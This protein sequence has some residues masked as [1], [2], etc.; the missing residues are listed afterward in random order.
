MGSNYSYSLDLARRR[1]EHGF[2]DLR[3]TARANG[4]GKHHMLD[5]IWTLP[6]GRWVQTLY[7]LTDLFFVVVNGIAV[8][9][10]RFMPHALSRLVH[11][12][13]PR[14]A[15]IP[16]PRQYATLLIVYA[17]LTLFFFEYYNLYRTARDRTSWDETLTVCRALILVTLLLTACMY[18]LRIQI[19]SRL[20]VGVSGLLNVVTLSGWRYVKRKVVNARIAR[21]EGVRNVLIV[22]A[23]ESALGVARILSENKHLGYA[24]RGIISENGLRAPNV[25]GKIDDLEQVAHANFIDEIF[26]VPPLDCELVKR[27]ALDAYQNRLDVRLVPDLYDGLILGAPIHRLHD[28]PVLTLHQ[29]PIPSLALFF[30]RILDIVFSTVAVILVS[31]VMLLIAIA[32][33]LDSRGSILYRSQR[34]GK[35][36]RAFLCYKFRTMVPNADA[37]KENL[38]KLNEREGPFFKITNDPRMTRLGKW[39]RKY[40]LDELP[41]L[42][43]VLNGEMSLVGPR[44]HPLDDY[45][46]YSV[47]HLRRLAVTPGI[48]GLWQVTARE[49]P[50]FATN[51]ALDLE[52]IEE[53]SPWMDIRILLKTFPTVFRGAG[54]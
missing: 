38:R 8:F 17:A 44:P 36:G 22:S 12:E 27:V 34:I 1:R 53:W 6:G 54:Q 19:A 26:I 10:A 2:L 30:K 35:K 7:V 25:L 4:N 15:S 11:E 46:R 52:Y 45:R 32:I 33:K 3:G 50:S 23:G 24:V 20:V 49:D 42:F 51:M 39:L 37:L 43:N 14:L 9:S 29:E 48:T 13:L 47:Q 21:G 16:F 41:Q 31:P 28:L 40:S 5:G 18:M